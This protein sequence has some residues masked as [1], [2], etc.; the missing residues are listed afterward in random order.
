MY[1]A[2][3]SVVRPSSLEEATELL[4]EHG[5]QAHVL[6]GGQSLIP[7]MKQR[8]ARPEVLIS[9]GHISPSPVDLSGGVAA[10]H[11]LTTHADIGKHEG[12]TGAFELIADLVPQI[13]DGQVRNVGTIG[14][15]LAEADPG[16][17]W[18]PAV[19]A[20][21][22][23]VHTISPDG[24]RELPIEDFF[25]GPFTTTLSREELIESVTMPLPP[26]RTG[27]AYLKAKRRQGGYGI[28][29][30]AVQLSVDEE[31]SV[32]SVGYCCADDASTYVHPAGVADR[33]VGTHLHS[34]V[35]ATCGD[36]VADAAEPV[37]DTMGSVE[38]KRRLCRQLFERAL[39]T[40][41][42]R[43]RGEHVPDPLHPFADE[44]GRSP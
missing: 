31:G 36:L 4:E 1:P 35:V 34:D 13:A 18:G 17:D 43:A 20:M 25:L 19:T 32:E 2:S 39:H 24:R 22:G 8:L 10:L 9:I 33:L 28:A 38:Y 27:G 14:G 5:Q 41:H 15:A 29:S 40:A 3:C 21:G 26:D 6:A 16:N 12:L 42:R 44:G 23:T 37:A 7:L 11:A 30:A